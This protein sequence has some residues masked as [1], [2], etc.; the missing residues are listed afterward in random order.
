LKLA[1]ISGLL[2]IEQLQIDSA[3]ACAYQV[4]LIGAPVKFAQTDAGPADPKLVGAAGAQVAL[5]LI[6]R[7]EFI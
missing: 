5:I 1:V 7:V 3:K 2:P 6:T 4:L